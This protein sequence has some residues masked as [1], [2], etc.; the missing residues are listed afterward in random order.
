[1][2]RWKPNAHKEV[3]PELHGEVVKT[4]TIRFEDYNARR[5]VLYARN[6]LFDRAHSIPR[7]YKGKYE[8]ARAETLFDVFPHLNSGRIT[9]APVLFGKERAAR[10]EK[11]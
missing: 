9:M 7:Q 2:V 10:A 6:L 3:L 4:I 11:S 5:A 8:Y 1:M